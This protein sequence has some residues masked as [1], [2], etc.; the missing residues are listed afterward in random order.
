M[1]IHKF[2]F[3]VLLLQGVFG[4]AYAQRQQLRFERLGFKEGLSELTISCMLQDS[5]GFIWVGT[6]DGLN[7]YDGYKFKVYRNNPADSLSITSNF[8][9]NLVEDKKGD[10]WIATS[11]GGLDRFDQHHDRFYHYRHNDNK[12][13]SIASDFLSAL[14]FDD[15]GKLWVA[16]VNNGLDCF[17]TQLNSAVHY[18]NNPHDNRSIS[19]NNIFTVYKDSHNNIWAGGEKAGLNLFNRTTRNFARFQHDSKDTT[20]MSTNPVVCIFED[21]G[22][23]TWIGTSGGGLNL[24]NPANKSFRHFLKSSQNS[25]SLHS[26]NVQCIAEDSKGDLWIGTENGGL[27][28]FS[29]PRMAF[30][31]SMHDDVDNNSLS[32]NSIDVILKDK[33]GNMWVSA[34]AG[35]VNL[36]K[37]N[38]ESFGHYKHN[39]LNGSLSNDFVLCLLQDSNAD[40]WVGT[41]GGGLNLLDK[42]TG[43]FK[44]FLQNGSKKNTIAGNY[45]LDIKQDH[46]KNLWIGTWNDGISVYNLQTKTFKTLK[47]DP[48][49][50]NSLAGNNIFS[51]AVTKDN[52]IWIATYGAGLDK[53]NPATSQFTHYRANAGP[54]S[55][56]DDKINSVL[57]DSKGR[58]WVG[59]NA[60]GI[61]L[62]QPA[63]HTFKH[64]RHIAGQNSLSNNSI[65]D[66][67]E[68]HVG[69]IWVCTIDGLNKLDA[70][71]GRFTVYK[72]PQ[73]LPNNFIY[74]CLEDNSYNLWISTNIGISKYSPA[75]NT[76]TNFT[77]EDGLQGDAFK[78]HSAL[79][80]KNGTLYFGGVNGFNKFS[81][82][83]IL[84]RT[85]DP[86]LVL[87][88]FQ[89][90][91]KPVEISSANDD[92]T[93]LKAD[94]SETHAL[95]L[96]HKQSVLTFEFSSLDYLSSYKKNYAYKLDGFDPGW[97]FIGHKNS[98]VYTNLPAGDYVLR[99]KSQNNEG[100]WSRELHLSL[101]V[102]PP[103]WLT[104]WFILLCIVSSVIIFYSWYRYR[105]SAIIKQ[106]AKL[107]G[108]VEERTVQVTRQSAQ[109]HKLNSELQV[110]ND[111]LHSQSQELQQQKEFE[112]QAR[113]EA[114]KANQAKSTFLAT[115]SHEIR[116]PMNGV[117]GMASLLNETNLSEEQKEY[118]DTII[119]CGNNLVSV[120]NDILDFSKIESGHMELEYDDFDLRL[121]IEEVM[122]LF[123]EKVARQGIDLIYLI[124]HELP[125]RI[126]GDSLRLKQVLIN[127]INNAIKFTEKGEVFVKVLL[128]KHLDHNELE[129]LFQVNDTGIG[130]PEDKLGS[131]FAAFTQIDSSTT[132]KYGGT[133]L[134]LVISER[135]VKLMGGAIW[136]TSQYGKGSSFNFTIKTVRSGQESAPPQLDLEDIRGK[137][138][139]IV[140]DNATNLL[141]L[142]TQLEQWEMKAFTCSSGAE[143]LKLLKTDPQVELLITDMKLPLMD[144][145]E[146]AMAA[147]AFKRTLPIIMLSS[148]GSEIRK[149][150]PGL[151]SAILTKPAKQR[152]LLKSI[153]MAI[154]NEK[155]DVPTDKSGTLYLDE[156]FARD[157]PLRILVAEDNLM[158]Q[159][160]IE[161]I[162]N[163]LGYQVEIAQNGFEVLGKISVKTYDVILMDVQMPE[164]DGLEATRIIRKKAGKQP[165]IVA[166]TA[167]AMAEDRDAC[168]ASG[169]NYYIAKPMRLE[170]ITEVLHKTFANSVA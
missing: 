170:E 38:T 3:L 32:N 19:E 142:K 56:G 18:K 67:F 160:L 59:T 27:S 159:R 43:D 61:E 84:S 11:G 86:P 102:L 94:I 103:F 92:S 63:T 151:F 155:Q 52:L 15:F 119:V 138:V 23:R 44:V 149:Q 78:P 153:H 36:Y 118:T 130:I 79:K 49:N 141:I 45:I 69:N 128:A 104:W 42:K 108:Q 158:N 16:T 20:S 2:L 124:D 140:D 25:N 73:G 9:T 51:M 70:E 46:Q 17:D 95:T 89:L 165:A 39:S 135:L 35:G 77:D 40:L 33:A 6:R 28:I 105:V 100:K 13:S 147:R 41:D 166:M 123:G 150:S 66:I 88:S 131:L 4:A 161:R 164:M 72:T 143:A 146:L 169:M 8:I 60:A 14:A 101:K 31:T 136:A 126:K 81:P 80:A 24:Y 87:T 156:S 168:F 132:R 98:A 30:T 68:D 122:D 106:K 10:L 22:H 109:L 76:F 116:T 129:I 113:Q 144:G 112:H 1:R 50:P 125:T 114:E 121:S 26:N 134:G 64:F 37:K 107:E 127:L 162:L 163:K 58:V 71:S 47:N 120:I 152:Q 110:I 90:Y 145:V 29:Y 53:Y 65:L 57:S 154:R 117:I 93:P 97:N 48:K 5:K 133:G 148:V 96:N 115:M 91:N 75:K 21:S 74:A 82:D 54:G 99:I 139:L 167:N 137:C 12:K 157:N 111:E 62:F 85:Y 34:F 55:L 83:S 7:R